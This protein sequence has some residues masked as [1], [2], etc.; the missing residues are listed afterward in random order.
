M[1]H[2]KLFEQFIKERAMRP[3]PDSDVVVDDI[4]LENETIISAAEIV[5]VILN[6]E[7][8]KEAEDFFYKKYG[9]NAFKQGEMAKIKEIWN[10]YNAE[11]KEKEAEEEKED[12]EEKGGADDIL[13]GL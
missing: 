3:N 7:T 6:T 4:E 12:G 13:A 5:G 1:K 11:E 10:E 9:E 8:E 2:I